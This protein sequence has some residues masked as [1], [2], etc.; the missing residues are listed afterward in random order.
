M[1]VKQLLRTNDR[2]VSRGRQISAEWVR[3][4]RVANLHVSLTRRRGRVRGALI[5]FAGGRIEVVGTRAWQNAS[6][7]I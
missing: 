4:R 6:F 3:T 7:Y 1:N 5:A 2:A